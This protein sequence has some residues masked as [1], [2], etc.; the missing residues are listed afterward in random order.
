MFVICR[1]FTGKSFMSL[2]Q[3]GFLSL[4]VIVVEGCWEVVSN[5][6]SYPAA[7]KKSFRSFCKVGVS[8]HLAF[9]SDFFFLFSS[10]IV[11]RLGRPSKGS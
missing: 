1:E 6:C 9:I 10:S 11:C 8:S 3:G 2:L 7:H 5:Y 4:L